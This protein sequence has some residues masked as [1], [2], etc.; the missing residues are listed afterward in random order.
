MSLM[1][2]EGVVQ[3]HL[4]G[5]IP[6]IGTRFLESSKFMFTAGDDGLGL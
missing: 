3:I 4:P 1:T 5:K 6:P 2:R